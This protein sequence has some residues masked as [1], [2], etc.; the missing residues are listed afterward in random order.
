MGHINWPHVS[1][2]KLWDAESDAARALLANK[3]PP[4]K[5]PPRRGNSLVYL[6]RPGDPILVM[7]GG[8]TF[9]WEGYRSDVWAFKI[10]TKSWEHWTPGEDKGIAPSGRDHFTAFAHGKWVYI[11]QG[12]G[13]EN[14]SVSVPLGDVWRLDTEELRW[15]EV[16][17]SNSNSERK[18]SGKSPLP[19]FL[20]MM[21][22]YCSKE[23]VLDNNGKV[24]HKGC[25]D[26]DDRVVVFGG[27]TMAPD[28]SR[29]HNLIK[30]ERPELILGRK[31]G[32]LG[33]MEEGLEGHEG[34]F[35]G[36]YLK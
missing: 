30:V 6:D 12:R 20:A 7:L 8:R 4:L 2:C 1:W 13:G 24:I 18:C 36:C 11:F 26:G 10:K 32:E 19:R 15:E 23:S 22:S 33:F 27:E 25:P 3:P 14:Y 5:P 17:N 35:S 29:I 16:S 28:R 34:S 9:N 21:S 31:S